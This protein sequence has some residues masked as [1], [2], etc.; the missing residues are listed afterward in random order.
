MILEIK[1]RDALRAFF[2]KARK[3]NQ[4]CHSI[5]GRPPKGATYHDGN[6]I[7]N[8]VNVAWENMET[9]E[10]FQIEYES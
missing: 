10:I 8:D 2:E 1:N 6:P 5:K 4:D 3:A 7:L 9:G